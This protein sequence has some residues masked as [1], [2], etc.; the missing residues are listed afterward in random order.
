MSEYEHLT[1][2]KD[3]WSKWSH[4]PR[5]FKHQCCECS[6][7]HWVQMKVI[8]GK[9]FMKWKTDNQASAVAR[10]NAKKKTKA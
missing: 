10:S 3:G 8:A 2:E 1:P 6:E 4:F 9:I 7:I 5:R